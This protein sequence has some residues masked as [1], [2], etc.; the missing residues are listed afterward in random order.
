MNFGNWEVESDFINWSGEPPID[1]EIATS[2]ITETGKGEW[3]DRYEWLLH[4]NA[5]TWIEKKDIEDLIAAFRYVAKRDGLEFDETILKH[6]RELISRI[7]IKL[8]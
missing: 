8:A 5:K 6:T 7:N 3:G 2:R 4:M 1:Y